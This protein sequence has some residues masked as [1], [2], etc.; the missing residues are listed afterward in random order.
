VV[1]WYK[2][3]VCHQE[4]VMSHRHPMYRRLPAF[5]LLLGIGWA[6]LLVLASAPAPAR[7]AAGPLLRLGREDIIHLSRQQPG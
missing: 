6:L 2:F 4:K 3:H 1:E 5:L 7:A